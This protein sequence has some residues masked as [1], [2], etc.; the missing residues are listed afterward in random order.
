MRETTSQEGITHIIVSREKLTLIREIR[1]Q[2][3]ERKN[4][5]VQHLSSRHHGI[6]QGKKKES[7][8][9]TLYEALFYMV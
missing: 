5:S 9:I 3:R 6:C 7:N 8:I 4:V 2:E 1:L